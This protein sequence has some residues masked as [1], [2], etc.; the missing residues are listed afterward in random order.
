[1]RI[2]SWWI[3]RYTHD[4]DNPDHPDHVIVNQFD[5]EEEAKAEMKKL[6]GYLEDH[7]G[8]RYEVVPVSR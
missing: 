4:P 1:M 6:V 2:T 3:I 5:T 8:I 7:M